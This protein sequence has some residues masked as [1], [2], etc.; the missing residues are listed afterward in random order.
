MVGETVFLQKQKETFCPWKKQQQT[1]ILKLF[2]T[3]GGWVRFLTSI[4][5]KNCSDEY[6]SDPFR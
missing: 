6:A 4:Y 3:A 5:T 1:S 2:R